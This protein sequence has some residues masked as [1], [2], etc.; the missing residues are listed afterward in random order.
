MEEK[1]ERE[2]ISLS[3]II[4]C[5]GTTVV[6]KRKRQRER[7]NGN[8]KI[9]NFFFSYVFNRSSMC[10]KETNVNNHCVSME[11]R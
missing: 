10:M 7:E 6:E 3:Y 9:N 11:D 5:T 2:R 1:G 4:I 8:S